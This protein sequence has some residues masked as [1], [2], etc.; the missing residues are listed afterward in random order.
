MSL[1]KE[2]RRLCDWCGAKETIK[3]RFHNAFLSKARSK[4]SRVYRGDR[5][6]LCDESEVTSEKLSEFSQDTQSGVLFVLLNNQNPFAFL[7]P[8][9]ICGT[10]K[11]KEVKL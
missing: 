7:T 5:L 3:Y 2:L 4:L 6:R 9:F 10:M 1:S 11:S 8:N